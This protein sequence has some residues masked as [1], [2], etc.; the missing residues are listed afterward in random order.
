VEDDAAL[1]FPGRTVGEVDAFFN[2]RFMDE[3]EHVVVFPDAAPTLAALRRSGHPLAIVTNTRN[4]LAADML[5]SLGL[6][7]RVD[8][9]VASGDV[10]REKPAPDM[11][12]EACRRLG[13]APVDAVMVGDSRYDR[14]AA[15]AAGVPFVG[16]R[17]EGD[18]RIESLGE[19]PPLLEEIP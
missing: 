13:T 17:T 7:D 1:L 9:V 5:A 2:T 3:I 10:P 14:E 11:P 6:A 16:Y 4:V 8:T 12:L 19:L 18:R 15:G